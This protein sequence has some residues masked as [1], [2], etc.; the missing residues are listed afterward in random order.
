MPDELHAEMMLARGGFALDVELAAPPG[1]TALFGPSGA[2]K[3]T[4]LAALA[5]L[6]KPQR[7]RIVLGGRV[8]FD[9][10]QGVRV[11]ARLR[12]S[13]YVV[14]ALALFPHLTALQNVT[15]GLTR[16]PAEERR[17]R[18]EAMLARLGIGAHADR[19]PGKLSGGERQRVAL[20]RALV[21]DPRILL[22]DEP[23]AALD[24]PRRRDLLAFVR[25]AVDERAIPAVFVSHDPD[26]VRAIADRVVALEDGRV[27]ASGSPA[28]VL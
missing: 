24:R 13:G 8:M 2:G 20:A 1:I 22:L 15:F 6:V 21:C 10:D 28:E 19:L 18:A 5:G 25:Q 14:Q 12:Q 4:V 7:G 26:E 27:T 3:S 23:F 9:S 11:P 17:A 16:V